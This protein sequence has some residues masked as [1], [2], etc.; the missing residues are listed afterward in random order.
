MY[1]D[2]IVGL[3]GTHGELSYALVCLRCGV[4]QRVPEHSSVRYWVDLGEVFTKE[5]RQCEPRKAVETK[6]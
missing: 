2:W 4:V 6:E 3:D 5:H 1:R